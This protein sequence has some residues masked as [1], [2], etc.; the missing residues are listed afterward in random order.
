MICKHCFHQV[1]A[2]LAP[3][4]AD[5][6]GSWNDC[7]SNHANCTSTQIQFLQGVLNLLLWIMQRNLRTYIKFSNF[8]VTNGI[9]KWIIWFPWYISYLFFETDF[10][11]QMLSDIK[12]FSR[13]SQT[14]LFINS[15]F[16]HCQSERQETWF[17]DDSPLIE[18]K[19]YAQFIFLFLKTRWSD[20]RNYEGIKV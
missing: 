8:L 16:A 17:A 9:S 18:D 6:L 5:P 10:R 13:S 7:K 11:N 4:S 12:D 1:Q 20:L 14:G 19:V 2:S 3:P 15:C